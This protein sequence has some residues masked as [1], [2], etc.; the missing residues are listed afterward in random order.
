MGSEMCIRDSRDDA[1]LKAVKTLQERTVRTMWKAVHAVPKGTRSYAV[2]T[3]ADVK[4]EFAKAGMTK[5]RA[6]MQRVR[7]AVRE[8][9]AYIG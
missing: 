1:F 2:A 5:S 4:T 8:F 3:I 7:E 6:W 9:A